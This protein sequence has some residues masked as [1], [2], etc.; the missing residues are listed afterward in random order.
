MP[1]GTLTCVTG[2]PGLPEPQTVDLDGPVHYREWPGP[3]GPTFVCVHG[4]GGSHL[5]WISVA[6]D[7][8]ARGRVLAPDLAGFGMTPRNGRGSGLAANRRLL[9]AFIRELASPPV[10]LVGNSMGGAICLIQAAYE[11]GSATGLILTSP[12]LP[13]SL[14]ARPDPLVVAGF[15]AYRLPAVGERFIRSRAG[16]LGPERIVEETLKIC[17]VDASRI[18][19]EVV[20]EH[21][22][23]ARIRGEDDDAVPSFLEAARS[24]LR[25]GTRRHFVREIMDRVRAPVLIVHG[26]RD[27]LVPVLW[28]RRAVD[29]RP[30]WSL[31]VIEDVGHIAMLEAPDRWLSVVNVWLDRQGLPAHAEAAPA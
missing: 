24:L 27:R 23:L 3:A 15:A 19:R 20:A 7:L 17:S 12:A 11:P 16:R 10:I 31:E 4:L 22:A 6:P 5:N 29:N 28:A 30:S 26:Q 2:S 18:S 9:S 1:G 14:R 8:A 25:L 13:W 21:V